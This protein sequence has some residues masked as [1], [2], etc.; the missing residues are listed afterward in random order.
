V[1]ACVLGKHYEL[2]E[3]LVK[4]TRKGINIGL[5]EEAKYPVKYKIDDFLMLDY[6]W[7]SRQNKDINGNNTCHLLFSVVDDEVLRYKILR[8]LV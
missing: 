6:W 4:D 1:D 8:L 2:L 7:K 3:Y 5:A